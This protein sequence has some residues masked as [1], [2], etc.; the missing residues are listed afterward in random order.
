MISEVGVFMCGQVW[1]LVDNCTL[2]LSSSKC[3]R[4]KHDHDEHG[5][6]DRQRYAARRE[7]AHDVMHVRQAGQPSSVNPLEEICKRLSN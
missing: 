1:A 7:I 4:S 6:C 5:R 3:L 2:A